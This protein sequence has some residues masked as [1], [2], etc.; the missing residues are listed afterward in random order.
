MN[1]TQNQRI[2]QITESTLI[3]GVDIAKH[4]HVAR[5]QNDRGFM[6]GKAFL[7]LVHVRDLKHSVIG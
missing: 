5:A 6:Y 7:S 3:V 2:S 1:Y 4:K